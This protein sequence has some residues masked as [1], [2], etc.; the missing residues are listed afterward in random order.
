MLLGARPRMGAVRLIG[1]VNL[2]AVA[3]WTIF[4]GIRVLSK[5]LE[6][7][8]D[9]ISDLIKLPTVSMSAAMLSVP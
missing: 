9:E 1:G 6:L 7:C 3:R 2:S 4:Y 5:S 8:L